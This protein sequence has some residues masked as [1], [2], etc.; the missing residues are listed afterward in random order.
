VRYYRGPEG[1]QR[2]WFDEPEIEDIAEDELMKAGLLPTPESPVTDLERFVE[3]HLGARLDQ[4]AELDAGILGLTEFLPARPPSISINKDLTGSALD[5]EDPLP[6][7]RGRWRATLA[8]EATHV[9]LHR[10]LFEFD[11]NQGHLFR[12][13]E[14]PSAASA[15]LLRCLKRDV[16]CR[17]GGADWREVQANRGMAALLMP[18]G[19][20]GKLART[21]LAQPAAQPVDGGTRRMELVADALAQQFE[22]S[23]QAARIRLATL[24]LI[25]DPAVPPLPSLST[26]TIG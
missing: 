25:D 19:V 26:E 24:K 8:H 12:V 10:S 9:L 16:G 11:V 18:R 14:L 20:F 4:Y 7:L 21:V 6:G 2:I 5:D 23:K 15:S 13:D 3:S 22:V 1:D 17:A